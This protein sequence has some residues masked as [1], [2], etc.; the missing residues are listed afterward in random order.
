MSWSF[1]QARYCS[2]KPPACKQ[3]SHSSTRLA[4]EVARKLQDGC[5]S[6][7]IR[8]LFNEDTVVTV[9]DDSAR[10]LQEKHP[11]NDPI[12]SRE[13]LSC[14]S[15]A[16]ITPAEIQFAIRSFPNGSAGGPD[17]LRPQHLKEMSSSFL[18]LDATEFVDALS[19][20]ANLMLQGKVPLAICHVLYGANLLP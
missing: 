6:G 4:K 11:L 20:V 19:A 5:I 15:F 9:D 13:S 17:G 7:A 14:S 10:I 18:G 16:P 12:V 8:V 3:S 1:G 2:P